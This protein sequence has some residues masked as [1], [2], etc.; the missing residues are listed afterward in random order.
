MQTTVKQVKQTKRILSIEIERMDDDSP[1]TSWLG[2]YS[3]KPGLFAIDRAHYSDCATQHT[4]ESTAILNRAMQHLG[5]NPSTSP[6]DKQDLSDALD[7]LSTAQDESYE[8]DCNL[9]WDRR[10]YRYFNPG[11]V[12]PFDARA[13]WI[14]ADVTDKHAYWERAMHENAILDYDRMERLN[15]G[16]WAFIGIDAKAEVVIGNVCQTLHSG[17]LWGIESDS[18]ESYLQE[19][20]SNQLAELRTI[21]YEMGFSKRAIAT[22]VEERKRG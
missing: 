3:D 16:D 9:S 14:P 6:Q 11:S 2:E 1:D 8:C 20:E 7:V 5:N 12:E 15:A 18:E 17:G 22:A 19:E 21:L 13:S 4:E 10:T